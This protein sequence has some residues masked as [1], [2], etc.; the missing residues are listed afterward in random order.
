MEVVKASR[1]NTSE[2]A[3]SASQ[4]KFV[5]RYDIDDDHSSVLVQ[6]GM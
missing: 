5:C 2:N 1:S 3:D 4:I 6:P